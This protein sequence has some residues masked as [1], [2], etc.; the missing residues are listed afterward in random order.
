MLYRKIALA[1]AVIMALISVAA[2]AEEDDAFSNYVYI[3]DEEIT[4]EN[5]IEVYD[6]AQKQGLPN[7]WFNILLMGT[8]DRGSSSKGR[9]DSMIVLSLNLSTYEAK[10]A[11]IMRD[12]WVKIDGVGYNKINAAN[13][14]GG[15]EL[16][17]RTVNENFG[18]NIEKYVVVNME[19][20]GE[21]VDLAGGIDM[22]ITKE[23]MEYINR[24]VKAHTYSSGSGSEQLSNYG[25]NIHLNGNQAL[26]YARI[27]IID[28]DYIRT[29]RQR[30]VLM[31]LARQ[32]QTIDSDTLFKIV[33][34]MLKYVDTNLNLGDI[35]SLV[36]AGLNVDT[37]NIDEL[38]LPVDGTFDSG[39]FD[40]VWCIK[41]NFSKNAEILYDY[42]YGSSDANDHP[43]LQ[44]GNQGGAVKRLQILLNKLGAGISEDGQF[45]Q[46]TEEALIKFQKAAGM[47]ESG[48]CND[49][50]WTALEGY[51]NGQETA[52]NEAQTGET[53]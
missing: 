34:E 19:G 46:A 2:F 51:A 50:V 31:Q 26:A 45:G 16:A 40:G 12:T 17:I 20:L 32:M 30:T 8:D 42:I 53:N 9:T 21:I 44:R 13:V 23:E 36:M 4:V 33:Y 48:I 1:L 10:L 49:E 52:S 22:D 39:I 15:P 29:E 41:P 47:V 11:S 5:L 38:R 35:A 24:Y 25:E 3:E 7:E 27:R 43:T 6:L 14:F 18:L 37:T 28:S